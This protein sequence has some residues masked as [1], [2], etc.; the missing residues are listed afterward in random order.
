MVEDNLE[1]I[2]NGQYNNLNL[3]SKPLK[4]IK[5]IGDG[6]YIIV[7]KLYDNVMVKEGKYGPFSIAQVKYKDLDCSMLLTSIE[8]QQ[9]DACGPSGTRVKINLNKEIY[10]NKMTGSESLAQRLSFEKV[11]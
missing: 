8:G 5:G 1:I 3:K 9:F 2:K 6:N 4:G 10:I 11:E 7:T